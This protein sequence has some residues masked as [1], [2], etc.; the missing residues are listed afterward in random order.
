MTDVVIEVRGGVLVEVYS[1]RRDLRIILV[2][3]DEINDGASGVGDFG[4]VP[5]RGMPSDTAQLFHRFKHAHADEN[6]QC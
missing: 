4:R 6:A 1:A 3:W 2:D 5:L